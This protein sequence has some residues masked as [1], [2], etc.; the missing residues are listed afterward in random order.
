MSD[1][2]DSCRTPVVR[3]AKKLE[4]MGCRAIVGECGWLAYFQQDVTEQVDVPVFMSALLQVPMVQ[5]TISADK[6]VGILTS[7][8]R[9]LTE[10]MLRAV[11]IDPD[12]NIVIAGADEYGCKELDKLY[13]IDSE[14]GDQISEGCYETARD[15]LVR[16]CTTFV[17]A[18][19]KMGALLSTCTGHP[20]FARA[21][22]SAIDLPVLSWGTMLDYA[23]SVTVHR[24]Y[25]GHV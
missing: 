20:P 25:Y 18:N 11:G 12:S 2:I 23:Y 14:A 5:R 13:H 17:E 1:H 21:I 8:A 9:G 19:P 4:R 15:E 10:A 16:A 7:E 24:D 3:A 22:Q 6:V